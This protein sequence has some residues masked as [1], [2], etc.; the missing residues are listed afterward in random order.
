MANVPEG[1]THSDRV[2]EIPYSP[3]IEDIFAN[4]DFNFNTL[5]PVLSLLFGILYAFYVAVRL[6]KIFFSSI[7]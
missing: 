4:L 5:Q 6:K 3:P 1:Y 7:D 2:P